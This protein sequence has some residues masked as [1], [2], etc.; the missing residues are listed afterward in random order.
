MCTC[1]WHLI[2]LWICC[3]RKGKAKDVGKE[4]GDAVEVKGEE[5]A[6]KG[7]PNDGPLE[8]ESIIYLDEPVPADAEV[9]E[10]GIV[11]KDGKTF[12]YLE[13]LHKKK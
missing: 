10:K 12:V 9:T 5:E 8:D 4:V 11:K 7:N 6:A 2:L 13:D 1:R 3:H